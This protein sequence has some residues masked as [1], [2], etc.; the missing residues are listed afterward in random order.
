MTTSNKKLSLTLRIVIGMAAGIAV[1]FLFQLLLL[2]EMM[3]QILL[4]SSLIFGH[5]LIIKLIPAI[6]LVL[7]ALTFLTF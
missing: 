5:L 2:I 3:K 7:Q 4:L 1:G 6:G